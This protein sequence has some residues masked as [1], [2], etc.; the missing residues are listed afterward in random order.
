MRFW[1]AGAAQPSQLDEPCRGADFLKA[2]DA[3][4]VLKE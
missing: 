4:V 1:N 2:V 3:L